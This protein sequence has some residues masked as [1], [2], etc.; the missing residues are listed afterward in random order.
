MFELKRRFT[1]QASAAPNAGAKTSIPTVAEESLGW[2]STSLFNEDDLQVNSKERLL[3]MLPMNFHRLTSG[4][5]SNI[6]D[7]ACPVMNVKISIGS[8]E[9]TVIFPKVNER[10]NIMIM[11]FVD[12]NQATKL[13]LWKILRKCNFTKLSDD[14]HNLLWEK[15]HYLTEFPGALPKVLTSITH[16]DCLS[17]HDTY[18][19]LH[20]WCQLSISEAIQLLLP[21]CSDSFA[22]SIAVQTLKTSPIDNTELIL[23][24]L[25]R[26]WAFDFSL[27][28]PLVELLLYCARRSPGFA[29]SLYWQLRHI[30]STN[31]AANFRYLLLAQALFVVCPREV[32]DLFNKQTL[33]I[34][35]LDFISN[36]IRTNRACL[37]DQLT[38]LNSDLTTSLRGTRLPLELTVAIDG[39][40]NTQCHVFSSLRAPLK[41][42]FISTSPDATKDDPTAIATFSAIYKTGDDITQD[43]V[44]LQL[45]AVMDQIW[46]NSGLDL[47]L[48]IFKCLQTGSKRGLVEIVGESE[49]LREIHIRHGLTG[50]F[51]EYE[52]LISHNSTE[53]DYKSAVQNFTLSCAAY[54]VATFILGIGDRHNDNIMVRRSGHLFHIDFGKYLGDTEKFGTFNRDRTAFVFT[55]DMAFVIYEKTR[56]CVRYQEFVDLCCFAFNKIRHEAN[57][58]LTL[59]VMFQDLGVAGITPIGVEYV[60]DILKPDE[61]DEEASSRFTNFLG[62][63]LQSRWTQINFFIHNLAQAKSSSQST[64]EKKKN[65]MKDEYPI[66]KVEVPKFIKRTEN[67]IRRY[68]FVFEVTRDPHSRS[69]STYRTY[70]DLTRFCIQLKNRFPMIKLPYVQSKSPFA[71]DSSSISR[72]R[73]TNVRVFV[74][75]LFECLNEVT[76]SELVYQF[77]HKN[78]KDKT[79][80]RTDN[81]SHEFSSDSAEMTEDDEVRAE[82]LKPQ[83][84]ISISYANG[85][86]Y[87]LVLYARNLCSASNFSTFVRAF[88]RPCPGLKCPIRMT[89]ISSASRNPSYHDL[90]M[91]LLS[92]QEVKKHRLVFNLCRATANNTTDE[93]SIYSNVH[94]L[95]YGDM[96]LVDIPFDGSSVTVW[97]NLTGKPT[98]VNSLKD[99]VHRTYAR[100][101]V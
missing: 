33:L 54:C 49:T 53:S 56:S 29:H 6:F 55:S 81:S 38:L 27:C 41:L 78:E 7:T 66:L 64:I 77:F 46:Q 62:K 101:S 34:D 80:E 12:L 85:I 44:T 8:T 98:L 52:W 82:L 22:R 51:R 43:I 76:K 36:K 24:Q 95:L 88:L 94:V 47:G 5:Y 42:A 14:E 45:I 57:V 89:K 69:H 31:D 40:D 70:D 28:S 59:L 100:P 48:L 61:T 17:I 67:R 50:S 4:N 68:Y 92:G 9:D 30:L 60:K 20:E 58:L 96:S 79:V 2:V 23:P 37:N 74:S 13:E 83:L 99:T 65:L 72:R 3:N 91:Y 11:K 19:L 21:Q 75:A 15:R 35:R 16:W 71:R 84:K 26:A 90:F 25:L 1:N 93:L 87:V 18:R 97:V 39:L 32:T 86:L 73:L 63:S 10:D